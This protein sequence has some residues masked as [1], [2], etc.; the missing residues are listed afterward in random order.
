MQWMLKKLKVRENHLHTNQHEKYA[1][2][3]LRKK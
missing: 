2:L 3:F 1:K